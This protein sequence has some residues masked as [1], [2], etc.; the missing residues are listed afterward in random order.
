MN[1]EN[2]G[3]AETLI[4]TVTTHISHLFH[5]RPGVVRPDPHSPI[6]VKWDVVSHKEENGQKV[7][8]LLNKVGKKNTRT[9]LGVLQANNQIKDGP[10]VVGE[11]RSPGIFPEVATYLYQQ[12]ANIYQMDNEFVARWAS[13]IYPQEHRDLKVVLAA[14]LLCQNRKGDPVI[15][16]GKTLFRDNDYREVGEAMVLINRKDDRGLDPKMV[17]RVFELLKV[18]GVSKINRELGFGKSARKP[19]IGRYSKTVEK[20]LSYRED[21]IKMLEGAVKGGYRTTIMDLARTVGYKPATEKFF[22]ILR[23]KQKQAKDGH[24]TMALNQTFQPAESWER[25]NEAQICERIVAVK[26]SFKRLVGMLPK[27]IGVTAAIVAAATQAGSLSDK[28]LI[29]LTPTLEELGL[30]TSGPLKERWESALKKAEDQRAANI[31]QNAKSKEVKEKLQTASEQAAQKVVEQTTK[32]MRIYVMVDISGSMDQCIDEAKELLCKILPVF[33]LDKLHVATF[34]TMG[35]E[36]KIQHASKAGVEMAFRGI[37]AGG[38][39][40]HRAAVDILAKYK[41]K[42]NEDS[43]FIWVGDSGQHGSCTDAINQSGLRPISFLFLKLG[44]YGSHVEDTARTLGIPCVYLTKDTFSDPYAAPRIIRNLIATT[45]V[46]YTTQQQPRRSTL[47]NDIAKTEL[48]QKPQ[49]AR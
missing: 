24:R 43:L 25:L 13:Y 34:N 48:L 31:A 15:E 38:G 11:Y 33:G 49:W 44:T 28:D 46:G 2:L 10:A 20:W 17:K 47:I 18:P 45:P 16:N 22:S 27:G 35:R 7:V 9:R 32:D 37:T 4:Q 40:F 29:I 19:F 39:T 8:Y 30:L 26:P 12:I 14:F 6:K 3:P 21:N 42:E 23:W 41:P 1:I 5:G 36:V